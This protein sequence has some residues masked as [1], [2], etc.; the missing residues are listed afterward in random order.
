MRQRRSRRFSHGSAAA[1]TRAQGPRSP[2][3]TA[4]R[5]GRVAASA[6]A[7]AATACGSGSASEAR[8]REHGERCF[9]PALRAGDTE[10]LLEESLTEHLTMKSLLVSLLDLESGEAGRFDEQFAALKQEVLHHVQIEE[11]DLLPKARDLLG[12][13]Q[14]ARI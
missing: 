3:Q 4:D 9:Y 7:G 11:Q 1:P 2:V 6:P 14:L 10:R 13:E 8:H 5:V 12:D